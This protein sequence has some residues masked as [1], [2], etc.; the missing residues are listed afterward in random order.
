MV[1]TVWPGNSQ[2]HRHGPI[3]PLLVVFATGLVLR[4]TLLTLQYT[5]DLRNFESG[6]H[7]LYEVGA[8]HI[9]EYGDF[10]NSLFLPR[11]PLYALG[12]NRALVLLADAL[13]GALLVPVTFWLARR[14][15]LTVKVAYLAALIVAVDPSSIV[16]SS[17]L[18]PEPLANLLLSVSLAALLA[19]LQ[20]GAPRSL[21]LA[22]VAGGG[23]AASAL[24]RPAAYMLWIVLGGW[25]LFKDRHRWLTVGVFV[26]SAVLP[27]AAWTVHN[28]LVFNYPTFSTVSGF[29]MLYYRAASVE[30]LATGNDVDSVFLDLTRRV[31][32]K[33]GHDPALVDGATHWGYHAATPDITAAMNEVSLQVFLAHPL[34]YLATIPIGFARMYGLMEASSPFSGILADAEIA[35]NAA[36]LAGSLVGL[37]L[38]FRRKRWTQFWV[39]LVVCAY[40]TGGTL[41][42]KSAGMDTREHSMLTPVMASACAF[43]YTVMHAP[44]RQRPRKPT[45]FR[46]IRVSF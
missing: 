44:R 26:V 13:V 32:A 8:Q 3:G 31:E 20:T 15:Q 11:P 12:G 17:F 14:F 1:T 39:T 24:V 33:L 6:D 18:G 4:L 21:W 28:G 35:W 22:I 45:T 29:T 40:F 27:I 38:S 16:F 34:M 7:I 41:L 46:R 19:A 30:H 42:V 9:L 37:W 10:S 23:L 2:R 43:K 25:A 36:F 5:D